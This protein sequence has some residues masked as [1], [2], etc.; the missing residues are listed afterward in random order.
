L[1]CREATDH[2]SSL[3]LGHELNW[4]KGLSRQRFNEL[5]VWIR[6]AYLQVLHGRIL[7]SQER[8]TLRANL[9]RGHLQRVKLEA[10]FTREE[11]AIQE[12]ESPLEEKTDEPRA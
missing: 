1:G 6:P 5:L 7:N 10:F 12:S 3:R 8:D 9:L 4:V 2:L 11:E